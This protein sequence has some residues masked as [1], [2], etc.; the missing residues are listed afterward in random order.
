MSNSI[1]KICFNVKATLLLM[2]QVYT[3]S[4]VFV[5]EIFPRI[6]GKRPKGIFREWVRMR[7][8]NGF[9]INFFCPFLYRGKL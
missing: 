9:V 4:P 8:H 5:W 3:K 2:R 6:L 1:L 7:V